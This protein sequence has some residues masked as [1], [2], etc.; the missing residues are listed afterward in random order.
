MAK[1]YGGPGSAFGWNNW[2]ENDLLEQFF[3]ECFEVHFN[4]KKVY[5]RREL[6]KYPNQDELVEIAYW[7]NQANFLF[8]FSNIV[9]YFYLNTLSYIM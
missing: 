6:V 9:I 3:L 7:T 4:N 1:L 8:V 5:S 2:R